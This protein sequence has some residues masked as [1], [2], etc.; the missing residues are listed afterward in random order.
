MEEYDHM[1]INILI[2]L[3]SSVY[4]TDQVLIIGDSISSGHGI[5]LSD[6]WPVLLEKHAKNQNYY[7]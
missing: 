6:S 5:R 1:L 2:L 7:I 4:A 3:L